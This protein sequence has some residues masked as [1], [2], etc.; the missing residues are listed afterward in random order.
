M[1]RRVVVT[2]MGVLSP[3]GNNLQ[4]SWMNIVNSKSGISKLDSKYDA[5]PCRIG[6]VIKDDDGQRIKLDKYFKKTELRSISPAASYALI[7]TKE[8]LEDAQLLNLDDMTKEV[9]GVAVGM[10]MVDLKD[11]CDTNEALLKSYNQVSPF[12]IPRILANMAAGQISI[13][14][15]FR[16]P[17]HSVSTACATGAHAIGDSFRFI[18]NGDAD[19]MICGGTEACISPLAIAAFCRLRALST[20]YNENPE[21]ASRP[22]DKSR[23]GF[24]MGEGSSIIV[25]EDLEHAKNRNA[26]IYGE[27]LGYGLSGDASHLTAPKADGTGALLAMQRALRDAKMK[28]DEIGYINAHATST[29]LGDSIETKAIKT[30]FGSRNVAVS[31]T[32]GAHGHLLGA[33]GNLESVFTIKAVQ[34]AILPPTLNLDEVEDEELNYVPKVSQKWESQSRRVALKNAFGFGGTNACLCIAQYV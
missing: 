9:T 30:L 19:I 14:Y 17:N 3:I 15:G 21:L 1:H 4:N 10:G 28:P 26:K 2:G 29:P 32:K 6:G 18:R 25:L 12:F 20:S 33:A 8:A 23:E 34:E 31:S 24:V 5:L 13:K 11:I 16:G 27:I 7:A 22:F